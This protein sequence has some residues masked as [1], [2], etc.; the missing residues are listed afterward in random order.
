[1]SDRSWRAKTAPK[2]D[3]PR[4]FWSVREFAGALGL[5]VETV[6]RLIARHELAAVKVGGE[7]RI[8]N[9]EIER[10]TDEAQAARSA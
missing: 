4:L 7:H 8:P 3:V 1:M 5:N 6:Y 9:S 10:L 2:A